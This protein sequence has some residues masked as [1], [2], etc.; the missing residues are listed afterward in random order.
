ML[1]NWRPSFDRT[2]EFTSVDLGDDQLLSF[3]AGGDIV[4]LNRSTTLTANTALTGVLIGTPITPALAANSL[5]ISNVTMD[6]DILIAGNDGGHSKRALF[7][8]ASA[9][10]LYLGTGPVYVETPSYIDV[11]TGYIRFKDDV[12][13]GFGSSNDFEVKY[14]TADIDARVLLFTL[15]ESDDSGDN[16][17]AWVF[18]EQTNINNINLGLLDE[19]VQPHIVAVENAG[20]YFNSSA[21]T[22][23][24]GGA[25]D[26]CLAT[27]I[28][29]N[30][31]VG[32]IVRVTAG[33]NATQGWYVIDAVDSANEV[34]FSQNWTTGNVSGGAVSSFHDFPMLTANGIKTRVTD[35]QPD[36]SM[37]D[38]ACAGY[39][40]IDAVANEVW[41]RGD[42]STWVKL[43]NA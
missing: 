10:A 38:I 27:G 36:D 8:D 15:D 12:L 19:V 5:I 34:T 18:G 28:G 14:E 20:R 16:V 42:T 29:T 32:D 24:D 22:S 33:T 41:F 2:A 1:K 4:L 31:V 39:I 30:A 26:E 25:T 7:Y 43:Q 35:G 40:A 9:T 6:G 13:C 3:G 17:P 23:D 11:T 21:V 37:L